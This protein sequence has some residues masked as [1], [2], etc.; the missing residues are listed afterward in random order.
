MI[1][2]KLL[3]KGTIYYN[4]CWF[5]T[6]I[7]L[8][9]S[10]SSRIIILCRPFGKVTFCC[11]NILILFLTTS[12]PLTNQNRELITVQNNHCCQLPIYVAHP[13]QQEKIFKLGHMDEAIRFRVRIEIDMG[14]NTS[15]LCTCYEYNIHIGWDI[16]SLQT[17]C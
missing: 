6:A 17:F 16:F 11:A 4:I 10:A 15:S 7:I 2:Y 13:S 5:Y 14:L 3:S 12:I 9:L 1:C 8:Y